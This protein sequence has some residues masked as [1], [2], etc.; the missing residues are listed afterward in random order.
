MDLFV[1]FTDSLSKYTEDGDETP[2]YSIIVG[3]LST[4][5]PYHWLHR[6]PS[7][8][9]SQIESDSVRQVLP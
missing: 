8:Q 7:F 4:W 9:T 1:Y 3:I 5:V 2:Q 6:F